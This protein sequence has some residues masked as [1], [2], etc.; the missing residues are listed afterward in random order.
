MAMAEGDLMVRGGQ[1]L[2]ADGSLRSLDLEIRAGVIE[3]CH[4][5]QAAA[6]DGP[7][8]EAHGLTVL[9]GVIDPKVHFRDPGLTHKED[10]ISASRACLRGRGNSI[11]GNA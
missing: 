2:Q 11:P 9:P 3:A 7:V 6:W 10:L 4:E 8:L 1:V 5:I